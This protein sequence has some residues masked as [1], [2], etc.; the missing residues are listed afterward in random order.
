MVG[1][2]AKTVRDIFGIR[3][4]RRRIFM[5]FALLFVF[6]VGSHVYLPYVDIQSIEDRL[7]EERG[8]VMEWIRYT[9]ALTGG[10]LENATFFSL[11]IMPY[12][13]ASIIMSLLVKVVP[14]LEA[15][16]KEG[17]SGRRA[18]NRYTRY[19][20]VLV[21]IVQGIFIVMF[22]RTAFGEGLGS[23]IAIL[24]PES[25]VWNTFTGGTQLLCLIFG[26]V[27]LMWLGEKITD[28]GIGNG[29][30]VLIM[31]GIIGRIPFAFQFLSSEIVNAGPDERPFKV[32]WALGVIVLF[33][34]IVAA[35]VFIT[36]GQRR[37]PIQ[38][39]RTVRGRRVYGGTKHYMP[40]RV[41]SAGV[42]PIIFAQALVVLPPKMIAGVTGLAALGQYFSPGTFWY[43]VAYIL[44]I[45][46]F[47][48]FWTTLMYNPV[49]VAKNI[50]EYGSFIP[51]IRPGRRTAEYLERVMSRI[52]LAGA[53][54][55]S[56]IALVPELVRGT[57]EVDYVVSSLLGGTSMLIVVGV[58]LDIVDKVEA[59]LLVRQYDGFV[60]GGGD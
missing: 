42:M 48:Y 5:T 23:R 9:G 12:I 56:I 41:N 36:R 19:F 33:V 50:Q 45:V 2:L 49:E 52:T 13:T 39:A 24:E 59:Q 34:A 28:Y 57:L 10:N 55:L 8:G 17:E 46:F 4:V 40:L 3:D 21:A 26:A 7:K 58:A 25:P 27:F 31:S 37:I 6:R 1:R 51:G 18:I 11:G 32:V 20:T 35:V 53:I 29:A 15:L 16:S 14:R 54:F 22:I 30:S 44:L 47:A 60:R 43:H 38:Q